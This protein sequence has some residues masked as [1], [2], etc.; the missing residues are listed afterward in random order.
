MGK[1][2]DDIVARFGKKKGGTSAMSVTEPDDDEAPPAEDPTDDSKPGAKGKMLRMAF[3]A[4]ND[5]A[6]EEAVRAIC[7]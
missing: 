6:I 2:A 5:E 7:D 1:F 3:K 4:G